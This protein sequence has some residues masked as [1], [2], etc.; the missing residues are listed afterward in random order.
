MCLAEAYLRVPDTP[1]LDALIRDKIGSADWARH[2]Q[3]ADSFTN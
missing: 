2:Q 3:G 1:T